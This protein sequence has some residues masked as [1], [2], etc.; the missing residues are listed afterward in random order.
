[1][2]WIIKYSESIYE[3]IYD[4][5]SNGL[6]EGARFIYTQFYVLEKYYYGNAY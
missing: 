5:I 3:S 2:N 4:N 1:M 6:Y